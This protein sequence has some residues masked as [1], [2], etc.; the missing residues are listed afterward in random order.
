MR[1]NVIYID[2]FQINLLSTLNGMLIV[3]KLLGLES[4]C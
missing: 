4:L 2:I 1:E 3:C